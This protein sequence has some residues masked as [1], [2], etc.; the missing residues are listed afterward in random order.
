MRIWTLLQ[1]NT[2]VFTNY[3]MVRTAATQDP[4]EHFKPWEKRHSGWGAIEAKM[5]K[6]PVSETFSF[7][8]TTVP[9]LFA[10]ILL[11]NTV[12]GQG[13]GA[14]CLT[15]SNFRYCFVW[16]EIAKNLFDQLIGQHSTYCA[17]NFEASSGFQSSPKIFEHLCCVCISCKNLKHGKNE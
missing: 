6:P 12:A 16:H 9:I 13:W 4:N 10:V 8:I 11:S 7:K 14:F 3:G 5:K 2:A 17:M 15:D 1:P